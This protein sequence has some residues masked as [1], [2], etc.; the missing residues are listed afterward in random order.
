MR[1]ADWQGAFIQ[2]LQANGDD[3]EL[4]SMV[5]QREQSRLSVYRNNAFQAL[6][7]GLQTSFPVCQ[8]VLGEGCFGQLAQQYCTAY[9]LNDANLN[10]YGAQFSQLL[11]KEI[12]QHQAFKGLEYLSELAALEWSLK[13]GYYAQNRTDFLQ[14]PQVCELEGL[15]QLSEAQQQQA[16]L[17]LQPDMELLTCRYPVHRIWLKHQ[18]PADAVKYSQAQSDTSPLYLLTFRERFKATFTLV[19]AAEALLLLAIKRGLSLGALTDADVDLN[20]LPQLIQ[21][22]WIAG[23]RSMVTHDG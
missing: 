17:L 11:A 9:P 21:Q 23:Y 8:T 1:L 7:N 3:S 4:L 6:L 5:N 10:H 18:A 15:G 12:K 22:G 16:V 19:S 13:Q 2:A 20:I 14:Q